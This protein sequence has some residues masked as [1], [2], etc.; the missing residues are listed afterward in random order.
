LLI[1]VTYMHQNTHAVSSMVFYVWVMI[2]IEHSSTT[3]Q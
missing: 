3:P 2:T 1:S